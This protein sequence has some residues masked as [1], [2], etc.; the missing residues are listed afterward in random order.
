MAVKINTNITVYSKGVDMY[1]RGEKW[2]RTQITGVG[3]EES[4]GSVRTAAGLVEKDAYLILIPI[5]RATVEIQAGDII[6]KGTVTDE[7]GPMFSV[8]ALK[9][10][11]PH[12]ACVVRVADRN[13]HWGSPAVRHVMVKGN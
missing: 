7:I 1:T 13:D 2:T 4:A 11:Y 8:S 5:A 6:I 9:A 3:W 10:K 12:D